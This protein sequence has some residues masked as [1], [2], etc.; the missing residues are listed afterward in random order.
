MAPRGLSC[1]KIFAIEEEPEEAQE[2]GGAW[3]AAAGLVD[4]VPEDL[5]LVRGSG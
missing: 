4:V 2:P 1:D 5:V 3:E